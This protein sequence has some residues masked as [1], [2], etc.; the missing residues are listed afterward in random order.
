M[1]ERRLAAVP[2]SIIGLVALSFVLQIAFSVVQPRPEAK[3][4]Q[5]T[6]P[7]PSSVLRGL[8]IGEPIALAQLLTLYLQAFDNQPGISIPFSKLDYMKVELWL[9]R[10]LE[11]D[12]KAQYPIL[13]AAQLYAQVPDEAKQRQ[14]LNFVYRQFFADPNR[15]WPWLAHAAIL[16]KHRLHDLPLALQYANAIASHATSP[17]VPSWAKQMHI[18]L[19]EDMGEYETARVL[20]GG[21]LASGTIRDPHEIRFLLERLNALKGAEKSSGSSEY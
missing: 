12:P 21:L 9:E 10:I 15:R 14:M 19:H 1:A 2:R 16:A 17:S 7:P 11:L 20:L 6:A 4:E 5:L 8:S 18:F 13:M 3:A